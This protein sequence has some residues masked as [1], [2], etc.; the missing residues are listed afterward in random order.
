MAESIAQIK[1]SQRLGEAG[2]SVPSSGGA[3]VLGGA[4]PCG[5]ALSEPLGCRLEVGAV[6]RA[7]Q[8][9]T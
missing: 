6:L 7:A 5:G 4:A 8:R 9:V 3:G 2:L 1:G